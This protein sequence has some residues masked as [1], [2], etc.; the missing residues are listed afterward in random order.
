MV[1]WTSSVMGEQI[2]ESCEK[3]RGK[4]SAFLRSREPREARSG[5]CDQDGQSCRRLLVLQ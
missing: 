3:S 2:R 5:D 4:Q 1:E